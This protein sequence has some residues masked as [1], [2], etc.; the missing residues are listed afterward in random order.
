M[1]FFNWLRRMWSFSKNSTLYEEW[2]LEKHVAAPGVT[3]GGAPHQVV[4]GFT[5]CFN[6]A[7]PRCMA[8]SCPRC[9]SRYCPS[10]CRNTATFVQLRSHIRSLL[11]A[12]VRLED[13][14]EVVREEL[15]HGVM[16][17]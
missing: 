17:S 16:N 13:L 3:G 2:L 1:R 9:C 4:C 10:D 15:V 5:D 11:T 8:R 7:D 12:G 6:M 14:E